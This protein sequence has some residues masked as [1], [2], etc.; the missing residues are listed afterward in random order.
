MVDTNER[1]ERATDAREAC[2]ERTVCAV[3][4]IE[5]VGRLLGVSRT[6]AYELDSREEIPEPIRVGSR[7]RWVRDELEAWLL[8]GAPRR[9]VWARTWPRVR[10][11]VMKR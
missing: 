5:E 9:L 3:L 6:T 2:G 7:K 4:D 1:V 10:R 11:E 8:H